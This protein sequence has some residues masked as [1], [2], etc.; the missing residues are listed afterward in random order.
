MEEEPG[1]YVVPEPGTRVLRVVRNPVPYSSVTE[2]V[3]V[4]DEIDQQLASVDRGSHALLI[5]MRRIRGRSEPEFEAAFR[6]WRLRLIK[7]FAKAA[8]L[9]ETEVGA[10]QAQRYI[11]QDQVA[12]RVFLDETDALHWLE[13]PS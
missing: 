7:G 8:V 1:V 4:L 12:T 11:Q 6:H 13:T 5:D 2:L 9:L 3:R 10:A